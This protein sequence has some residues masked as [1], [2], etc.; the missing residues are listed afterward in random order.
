M[1][2]FLTIQIAGIG[3]GRFW[4]NLSDVC[5]FYYRFTL[6]GLKLLERIYAHIA[7]ETCIWWG[8]SKI[9]FGLQIFLYCFSSQFQQINFFTSNSK[10]DNW[11]KWIPQ[12]CCRDLFQVQWAFGPFYWRTFYLQLDTELLV[13]VVKIC[14]NV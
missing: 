7:S 11:P 10:E 6:Y 14:G 8:F 1:H 5:F 2:Y 9:I 4:R 3:K 13:F 12:H